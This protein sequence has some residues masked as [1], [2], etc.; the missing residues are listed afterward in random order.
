VVIGRGRDAV[1]CALSTAFGAARLA[2]F[3][4]WSDEITAERLGGPPTEEDADRQEAAAR[5]KP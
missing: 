1:D 3:V 5:T 2:K 4:V